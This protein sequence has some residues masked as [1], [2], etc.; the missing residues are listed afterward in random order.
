MLANYARIDVTANNVKYADTS[1][2][3]S[4]YAKSGQTVRYADTALMLANYM[5]NGYGVQYM[6]T[7]GMFSGYAKTGQ[8]VKYA[9]TAS[10][11]ANYAKIDATA[12]SVK[13]ADTSLLLT[14]YAKTGQVVRYDD[15]SSM[16]SNYTL[17]G[18]VLKLSDTASMLANYAKIDA[19]AGNVKYADTS[20]LLAGYAKSGQT[21]RYNDTASMLSNYALKGTVL[22]LSDTTGM[23]AGRL[24]VLDTAAM[25]ANY[26]KVDAN[27]GSV[28]YTDTSAMLAGYAKDGQTV[29][30]TDT[31]AM[32]F[33]KLRVTD[34]ASM[35]SGYARSGQ[36]VVVDTSSLSSRINNAVKQSDSTTTY[37]TPKQLQDTAASIRASMV[38][39]GGVGAGGVDTFTTNP[40]LYLPTGFTLG[41]YANGSVAQWKGLTAREAL[42]EAIVTSI[43]PTYSS[44]TVSLSSSPSITV[45]IGSSISVSLNATFN[46]NDGGSATGLC[47]N[48]EALPLHRQTRSR[49]QPLLL[50]RHRL[51]ITRGR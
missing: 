16:L 5:K 14:G 10:M 21:V 39:G 38:S 6:D 46:Q 33:N 50:I 7:A 44:P 2:L 15:T 41:K 12:N 13:Y 4:G 48:E 8:T 17:K 51:A 11:L 28:K 34:T 35:L 22:K 1:S 26:A 20:L 32:G 47:I 40:T 37:I 3:L 29:K 19:T 25:L 30:Y 45:E 9:D 27:S 23:L 49:L 43:P 42:L 24:S 18:T 31:F 36:I